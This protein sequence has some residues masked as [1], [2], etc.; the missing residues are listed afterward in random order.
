VR[1]PLPDSFCTWSEF[2][3]PIRC[4]ATAL[5]IKCNAGCNDSN[6]AIWGKLREPLP[7]GQLNNKSTELDT[8]S[9]PHCGRIPLKKTATRTRHRVLTAISQPHELLKVTE[10]DH[11]TVKPP[12]IPESHPTCFC[13]PRR[14]RRKRKPT[15]PTHQLH[16]TLSHKTKGW[17]QLRMPIP[18]VE[19]IDL[20]EA[21]VLPQISAWSHVS[22]P[23]VLLT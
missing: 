4:L 1:Y 11:L 16:I 21:C 2:E 17:G 3:G 10:T 12:K 6:T 9:Q 18:G 14:F 15:A 20:L 23:N 7:L 5:Q 8:S 19:F 22:R 13:Q